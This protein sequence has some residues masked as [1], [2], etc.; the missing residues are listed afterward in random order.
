MN[1]S[2]KTIVIGITGGVATGKSTVANLLRKKFKYFT[3]AD[4]I[5][6]RIVEK[7]KP[8]YKKLVRAFGKGILAKNGSINRKALAGVVFGDTKKRK[9]LQKIT[10]P[11]IISTMKKDISAFSK[12]SRIVLFEAPLLFE[13]SLE[14]IADIIIVV[15][16]KKTNQLKRFMKKGYSKAETERRIKAQLP[17]TVKIQRADIVIYNN[18]NLIV[19]KKEVKKLGK[20]LKTL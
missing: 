1:A 4:E 6:H 16:S 7:G 20:F 10:H 19:L 3:S 12:R 9:L 15:V 17:L 18:K 13:A 8:A 14:G 11:K 2:K 5:A